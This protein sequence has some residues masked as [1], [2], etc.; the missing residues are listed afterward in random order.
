MRR[1]EIWDIVYLFQWV[2]HHCSWR[3]LAIFMIFTLDEEG[4]KNDTNK[5]Q[6]RWYIARGVHHA[7]NLVRLPQKSQEIKSEIRKS[8]TEIWKS[9]ALWNHFRLDLGLWN[10]ETGNEF[11]I[12]FVL[13]FQCNTLPFTVVRCEFH[14]A[15][16][17]LK[18]Q[19]I[20]LF[21]PKLLHI[22]NVSP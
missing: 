19:K 6:C 4:V 7:G 2:V 8:A 5:K 22:E 21:Y 18:I 3:N 16:C 11:V 12:M 15:F 13:R 20:H 1:A 14:I 9:D 10:W 17:R